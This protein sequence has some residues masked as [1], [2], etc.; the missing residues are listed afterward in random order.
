MFLQFI[1][2]HLA[3]RAAAKVKAVKSNPRLKSLKF[4]AAHAKF[5][6]RFLRP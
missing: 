2:H 6:L 5:V 3:G 1:V 4:L